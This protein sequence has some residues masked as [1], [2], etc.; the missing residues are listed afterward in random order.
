MGRSRECCKVNEFDTNN[1]HTHTTRTQCTHIGIQTHAHTCTQTRAR[2]R[3]PP[4]HQ[5]E[6]TLSVQQTSTKT[7]TTKLTTNPH[8]Q[9]LLH[10]PRTNTQQQ[11]IPIP[12][13]KQVTFAIILHVGS[14]YQTPETLSLSPPPPPRRSNFPNARDLSLLHPYSVGPTYQTTHLA[15]L[16][17]YSYDPALHI[18]TLPH[19][20]HHSPL[21]FFTKKLS[22]LPFCISP[23]RA[24]FFDT[25]AD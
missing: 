21:Y 15:P 16:L 5:R 22:M 3:S 2:A 23:L 9:K 4:P 18:R 20:P 17:H 6:E 7:T 12:R 10:T 13:L 11:Q 8:R 25:A 14:T 24:L 19:S 1:V